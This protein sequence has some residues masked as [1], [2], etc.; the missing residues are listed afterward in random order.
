M[1]LGNFLMRILA[2][3]TLKPIL[4][5]N[6]CVTNP[7]QNTNPVI[8]TNACDSVSF[9][10]SAGNAEVLRELMS[11]KIP[12][13]YSGKIVID[14]KTVEKLFENKVFSGSV[15][16]IVKAIAPYEASLHTIEKEVF[17]LIKNKAKQSPDKKLDEVM[18]EISSG[19]DGK[20]RKLQQPIF[21][22]LEIMAQDMP[23]AQ[24]KQFAELMN[25][26][27]KKLVKEPVCVPFSANEFRYKLKRI[28]DEINAKN[29]KTEM[30]AIKRITRMAQQI[31]DI[32]DDD[33]TNPQNIHSKAKRIKKTKTKKTIMRKRSNILR[34]IEN[35]QMDSPLKDNKELE[36]LIAQTRS[37]IFNLPLV[38]NFNRKSFIHDLQKI[39]NTL[40]D[41]NLAKTMLQTAST[42]PKSRENVAAFIV[43]AANSSSEKIGYDL[44]EGSTGS[45]EHLIPFANKGKDSLE[46]Y[47]ISTAYYNSER[48]NRNMEQQLLRH[49][50]TYRNC[51]KQVNRLI[52]LY[53]NG[54]FEKIG[55]SKWYILNFARRM[56]RLS[57]PDNPL[58]LDLSKLK[59]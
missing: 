2:N 11:Y 8:K 58:V 4:K 12:D 38:I 21:S 3:F 48:G 35:T 42:L 29:N 39:T 46:N 24:R 59:K 17:N 25:L 27:N 53:N 31:S 13:M 43:K 20:L 14:P 51:Q 7:T 50:E 1:A 49:P 47:G 44:L 52:E 56:F 19:Y 15:K 40:N 23:L 22:K 10:R 16:N 57:P 32:V 36:N 30:D 55:L 9:G 26:V 41:R 18:K 33:G 34:K 6:N 5:I 28:A 37:K 45:I 54:T